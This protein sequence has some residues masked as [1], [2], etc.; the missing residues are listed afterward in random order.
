ML[1]IDVLFT[2]GMMVRTM[3][4]DENLRAGLM[5]PEGDSNPEPAPK[6]KGCLSLEHQ[7]FWAVVLSLP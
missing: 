1:C 6:G 4:N 5:L 3:V 2:L 7:G